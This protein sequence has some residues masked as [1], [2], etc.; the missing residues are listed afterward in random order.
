LE[1]R[2]CNY[3]IDLHGI[4]EEEGKENRVKDNF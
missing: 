4:D 1:K 2:I 3:L